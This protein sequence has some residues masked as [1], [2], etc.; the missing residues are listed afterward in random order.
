MSKTLVARLDSVG[1]VLLTGPAVRSITEAGDDVTFLASSIGAPAA[2]LLPGVREIIRFDA[3][4]VLTSQPPVHAGEVER[5]LGEVG[6]IRPDRAVIFTSFHQSPLPLALLLRL[7]GVPH[8]GATS[9]DYPGSLLDVRHHVSPQHHEVDR[10]LSLVRACGFPALR[11]RRL[12]VDLSGRRRPSQL[13]ELPQSYLAVHPGA[14]SP[15]RTAAPSQ[16]AEIVWALSAAGHHVL[17]T[18]SDRETEPVVR[19]AGTAANVVALG[20]DSSLADLAWALSGAGAVITGNTG[21]AH[22]AA[23]VGTPVVSLYPPTVPI[24]RW[25]PWGVRHAVLG[26]QRIGCRG[27]RVLECPRVVEGRQ[28]CLAAVHPYEVVWM[29]EA[30]QQSAVDLRLEVAS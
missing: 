19:G 29:A 1:D 20:G 6:A 14:S 5:L 28:P 23:A 18:G 17:L 21:P 25:R 4:W 13:D 2:E 15:A 24:W 27:C 11:D 26:D 30:V 22:L 12:L 10:N 9:I 3:P 8:I 7:A 16:W